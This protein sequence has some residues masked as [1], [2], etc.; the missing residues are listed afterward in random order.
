MIY[1]SKDLIKKLTSE[2]TEGHYY[3]GQTREFAGPL[4]PSSYRAMVRSEDCLTIEDDSRLRKSG[5]QF[6]FR[7]DAL[8]WRL[9]ESEEEYKKFVTEENFKLFIRSHT[10][11]ALGY[12][13]SE[14][15]FQQMGFRSEG[16]DVT[17]NVNIAFFFA[18]YEYRQNSYQPRQTTEEPCIIYRW[19]F[20]PAE[21]TFD[22]VNQYDF[23]TCPPLIPVSKLMGLFDLCDTVEEYEESIDGYRKAI[24]WNTFYFDLDEIR[25]K[26]P[27]HLINFPRSLVPN[28]RVIRQHAALLNPDGVRSEEFLRR[29]SVKSPQVLQELQMGMFVEDLA[30]HPTCER[31][32]FNAEDAGEEKVTDLAPDEVFPKDDLLPQL[33]RGWLR[34]LVQNPYG[35]VPVF[36]G[37]PDM[38]FGEFLRRLINEYETTL[39]V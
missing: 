31:F 21:W 12:P 15:F 18:L 4:W 35:T 24:N 33:L 27:F 39:F 36:S 28:S 37:M 6:H 3:R 2:H 34:T 30:K 8:D 29:H 1:N 16:L 23:N 7:M 13:L 9:F 11:N 14:A 25:G 10:R 38:D 17:D 26:R 22:T 20:E 19:Y 5:N 32:Y